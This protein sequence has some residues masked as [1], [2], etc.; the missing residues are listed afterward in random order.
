VPHLRL[1]AA[2]RRAE[3]RVKLF[4]LRRVVD[5]SG[6]SGTGLVA[7]G[8]IFDTGWCVL[9]WLTQHRSVAFYESIEE[10][11]AIHG[12]GGKTRIVQIADCSD[13][14]RLGLLHNRIQDECEGVGVE[15][16]KGNAAYVWEQ[17]G[18]LA[19]LFREVEIADVSEAARLLTEKG[20][21]T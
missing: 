3:G 4:E 11:I 5:E 10:V 6:V 8:V 9:S 21:T 18:K 12:H 15:F 1:G 19:D 14:R 17:R 13:S 16:T 7:Q 2:E 20:P